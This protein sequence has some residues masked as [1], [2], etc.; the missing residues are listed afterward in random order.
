MFR[1]T[2]SPAEALR[3]AQNPTSSRNR[4]L[5]T[6]TQFTRSAVDYLQATPLS[7][8]AAAP[9]GDSFYGLREIYHERLITHLNRLLL[10]WFAFARVFNPCSFSL[11]RKVEYRTKAISASTTR[12]NGTTPASAA[13]RHKARS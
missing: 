8:P 1:Q 10:L 7:T 5:D 9:Q 11:F 2:C 3:I 12:R 13:A 6:R 4:H